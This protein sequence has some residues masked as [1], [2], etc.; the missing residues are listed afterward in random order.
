MIISAVAS[1]IGMA[2]TVVT[3]GNIF[4]RFLEYAGYKDYLHLFLALSPLAMLLQIFGSWIL[5]RT[6]WRRLFF[7]LLLGPPRMIWLLIVLLPAVEMPPRLRLIALVTLA[8]LYYLTTGPGG[9]AWFSWMRDLVP[10]D[11]RGRYFGYRKAGVTAVGAVWALLAGFLLQRL[12]LDAF[13][14]RLVYSVSVAFG[15]IDI[16]LFVFVHHPPMTTKEGEEAS[17]RSMV[18]AAAHPTFVKYMAVHAIWTFSASL[19]FISNYKIMRA[20]G[21]EIFTIQLVSFFGTAVHVVFSMMWG[22]FIDHYGAKAAY[23]LTLLFH[24]VAPFFF[25]LTPQLGVTASFIGTAFIG[26]GVSGMM[27]ATTNLVFAMSRQ[28]DVAMALSI[29]STVFSAVRF[30]CFLLA[31]EVFYPLFEKM[32]PSWADPATFFL[33]AALFTVF[34]LRVV[35]FVLSLSLP[36][37]EEKPPAGIIVW[38]FLTTNPLRAL[39]SFSRF[40]R[41]KSSDLIPPDSY[42]DDHPSARWRLE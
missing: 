31:G 9:N 39:H 42:S 37:V 29:R 1:S 28:E 23:C 13:A 34:L 3:N 18:K 38:M 40:L 21:L 4:N 35:A 41:I 6:G 5:Q 7:Y 12:G 26:I 19:N 25:A 20:I 8:T 33:V 14:F 16:V 36:E 24:A 10:E 27:V 32:T 17:L 22:R 15:L 30:V 2:F 11:Y